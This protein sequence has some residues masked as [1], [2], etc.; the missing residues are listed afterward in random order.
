MEKNR[1]STNWIKKQKIKT[2][3]SRCFRPRCD[4]PFVNAQL[5]SKSQNASEINTPNAG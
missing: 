3:F 5:A 1:H 2:T 4:Y